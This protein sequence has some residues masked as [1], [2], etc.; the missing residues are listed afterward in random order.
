[1]AFPKLRIRV[2]MAFG[3]AAALAACGGGSDSSSAPAA[4]AVKA[5]ASNRA[6]SAADSSATTIRI[7]RGSKEALLVGTADRKILQLEP[8]AGR[9]L[10][11]LSVDTFPIHIAADEHNIFFGG[12]M[13]RYDLATHQLVNFAFNDGYTG[14]AGIAIAPSGTLFASNLYHF[15]PD[16]SC[17]TCSSVVSFPDPNGADPVGRSNYFFGYVRPL[18][19]GEGVLSGQQIGFTGDARLLVTSKAGDGIFVSDVPV[20][21]I[22]CGPNAIA[23]LPLVMD[24]A[25][26]VMRFALRGEHRLLVLHSTGR[27]DEHDL[28]TGRLIRPILQAGTVDPIDFVVSQ[29]GT[30]YVLE[31]PGRIRVFSDKGRERSTLALPAGTGQPLS[32]AMCCGTTRQ[33]GR[34]HH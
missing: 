21:E 31:K 33:H 25:N 27:L 22:C 1:M 34:G 10:A 26:T 23:F 8:H 9:L 20:E 15:R 16:T 12:L 18:A 32:L 28:A 13:G 4:E 24:P 30:V 19:G 3:L 29:D 11:T 14:A 5:I 17:G 6:A 2:F 7:G